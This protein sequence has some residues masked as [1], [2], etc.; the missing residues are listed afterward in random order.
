LSIIFQEEA[1]PEIEN[2]GADVMMDNTN[3]NP[4]ASNEDVTISTVSSLF[5]LLIISNLCV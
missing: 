1:E 2:L 5:V 4:A 3:P